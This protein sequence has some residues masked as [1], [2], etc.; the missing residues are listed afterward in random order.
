MKALYYLGNN[1]MKLKEAAN[2]VP[3]KDEYLI[4]IEACGICGSDFEGYRGKTGR[5]TPPMIMGHECAGVVLKAPT[6]GVYPVG[7]KVTVFPNFYCGECEFCRKGMTN[8][9]VNPK[10][11]GVFDFNG[12][13][14]QYISVH[15]DYLVPFD[16]SLPYEIAAMTEPLAV[17]FDAVSKIPKDKIQNSEYIM[18]IG[19]GTIGLLVLMILK[20]INAGNVIVSDMFDFR[21]EM[22]KNL[23]AYG[24]VNPARE[25]FTSAVNRMT[26]GKMCSI[27]FEAVGISDTAK[28]SVDALKNS[29]TSVWIGNAHKMVQIDMQKVVTTE[30]TI[31]GSHIYTMEEFKKCVNL[32]SEKVIDVSPLITDHYQL[33]DGA[34]AFYALENN[35]EGKIIKIM[36]CFSNGSPE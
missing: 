21:L 30:C 26:K 24:T 15:E 4:K 5:R 28:S 29:G 14:A 1:V 20:Q 35:K 2:P 23:G 6:D 8:K 27:T 33:E 25:D 31:Q 11:L 13:M 17:A 34:E 12:C 32:L 3:K 16:A 9:C 22:A 10:F 18:V 7:T 36:L 19:G